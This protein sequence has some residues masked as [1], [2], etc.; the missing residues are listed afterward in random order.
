MSRRYEIR[1]GKFGSYFHDRE[2]GG[3]EG[4]HMPNTIV[5]DKLNRLDDYTKRLA[6]ANEGRGIDETY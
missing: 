5:L 2:R 3:K 1:Q 6:K 4:F